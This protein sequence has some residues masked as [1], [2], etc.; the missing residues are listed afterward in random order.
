MGQNFDG[1]WSSFG[2]QT[3]TASGEEESWARAAWD[4]GRQALFDAVG[5]STV[6]VAGLHPVV[7]AWVWGL[8]LMQ[9]TVLICALRGPDGVPK[10]S[11][12]KT[13]TRQLRRAILHDARPSGDNSFMATDAGALAFR[14]LLDE[15]FADTDKYPAHF[16]LHLYHA[17]EILGYKHPHATTR[18]RWGLL[19]TWACNAFHMRVELE[20]DLDARL[21][22]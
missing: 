22:R 5:E 1:W 10:D 6:E 17:A 19:Y 11:P 2:R 4:A 7:Q 12:A 14:G 20:A 8:P 15:F 16:L 21:N 13:I 18:G 9:Q 3:E